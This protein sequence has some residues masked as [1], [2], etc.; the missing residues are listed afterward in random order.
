MAPPKTRTKEARS[1][2]LDTVPLPAEDSFSPV[3]GPGLK[4]PVDTLAM[5]P[6]EGGR[7]SYIERKMYFTLMWF[8]QKQGW[9]AG[10][11]FFSAPLSAV[12]SKMDYNS[13]NMAVIRDALKAMTTTAI[14]WQSP[15]ENEGSKWGVSGMISHAEIITSRAGSVLEWS[16]SPKVRPTILDPHPYARGSLELQG[17]LRT[18]ASL[19][20]YDI[21]SRYLTSAT[22]LTPRRHWLWWRPVLTGGSDGLDSYPEFKTFNRDV[23]K[24]A[25]AEINSNSPLEVQIILHKTGT[26]VQEIQFRAA[27]KKEYTPPLANIKTESGLKEIGRAIAAGVAQKQAE[28]LFEEHGE[29][30]LAKGVDILQDRQAKQSLPPVKAPQRYLKQVLNNNPIDAETGVLVNIKK[31][32]AI[33]KQK[34]LQL[35]E[36][37]RANKLEEAWGLFGQSNEGDKQAISEQF[38]LQELSRAPA[39]IQR[40]YEQKGLQPPAVRA[41]MRNYLA[42]HFFGEFWNKPSDEELFSFSLLRM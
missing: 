40:L 18:Y 2:E 5:T 4:K 31:E 34:R 35:L 21:C 19:A 11:E 8:A 13:R 38:R 39:S 7:I 37:Y 29:Q 14:E 36:Q 32:D 23:I 22:G 26:R 41:L 9:T 6:A 27:R 28:L 12:L 42:G 3:A 25:I 33:E 10:Q 15:T 30:S 1:L 16:Y 24:R 20:L 17:Q